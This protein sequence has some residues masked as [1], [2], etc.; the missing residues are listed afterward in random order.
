MVEHVVRVDVEGLRALELEDAVDGAHVLALVH[1]RVDPA[2]VAWVPKVAQEPEDGG[3]DVLH[4]DVGAPDEDWGGVDARA[5]PVSLVLSGVGG[6]R[7]VVG[8]HGGGGSR[9]EPPSPV[10]ALLPGGAGSAA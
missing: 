8:G 5:A 6:R 7:D 3:V 10:L 2:G 1:H 9:R 4:A